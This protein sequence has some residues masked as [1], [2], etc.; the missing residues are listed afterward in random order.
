MSNGN[1]AESISGYQDMDAKARSYV[2][3]FY[4]QIDDQAERIAEQHDIDPESTNGKLDTLL[5]SLHTNLGEYLVEGAPLTCSMRTLA[6]QTLLYQNRKMVSRPVNIKE[7]SVLRIPEAR[8]ASIDGLTLANIGDAKGGLRDANVGGRGDEDLNIVSFGNCMQLEDNA[9]L[10]KLAQKICARQTNSGNAK[11]LQEILDAM[12]SAIEQGKGTCYCCMLLNP[13]WEN[14]P[15]YYDY[16]GNAYEPGVLSRGGVG[17]I[18]HS[19]SYI[20]Y[21]GKEGI[22]MMSMIFCMSGGIISALDSGQIHMY[23]EQIRI[24][25]QQMHIFP[26]IDKVSDKLISLLK[27]YETGVDSNGVLLNDG[28]PA[29]QT[30]HGSSDDP[31]VHTIGWGHAMHDAKKGNFTFSNGNTENLYAL[32]STITL[33]QAEEILNYDIETTQ[34]DINRILDSK[35]I[36]EQVNQ[37]FYDALFLLVYQMGTGQLEGVT[38]L[39]YFLESNNFD[40]FNE[41]EIKEQFGD[42]TNKLEDGTMRRR[43]DELDIIF[44]D[45]YQRD[46]D[47]TRYGDI[48]RK[49]SFPGVTTR[50]Y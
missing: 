27:S 24:F 13:E 46:Y 3:K 47:Q 33:E 14:F 2:N 38:H 36:R 42:Y 37:Q 43:A 15:M 28:E 20:K 16:F 44:Y 45:D 49:K 9:S 8:Y 22:N 12:K 48:W 32:G 25:P 29:L 35:G 34:N 21:N 19:D 6:D 39:S 7:M 11:T 23:P 4:D 26:P 1:N 10:E 17:N 40:P 18:L 50:G 41:Q 5:G 31:D 30:Y